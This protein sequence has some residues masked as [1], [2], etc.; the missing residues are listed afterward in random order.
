MSNYSSYNVIINELKRKFARIPDV[1]TVQNMRRSADDDIKIKT[2]LHYKQ[3]KAL[4]GL[5][6]SRIA[7]ESQARTNVQNLLLHQFGIWVYRT[8]NDEKGT[9]HANQELINNISA[10]F[11]PQDDDLKEQVELIW[12]VQWQDIDFISLGGKYL[13][14]YS[15]GSFIMQELATF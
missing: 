8:V 4:Q 12:P 9:E 10:E 2:L 5:F 15:V 1:G 6:F 11:S 13:C 3:N 14:H 7:L